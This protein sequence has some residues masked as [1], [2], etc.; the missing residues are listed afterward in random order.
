MKKITSLLSIILVLVVSM[1]CLFACTPEEPEPTP[2]PHEHAFVETDREDPTCFN[3]G[4]IK[5][6]CE[7][8][9]TKEDEIPALGHKFEPK[10][11]SVSRL[12]ECSNGTCKVLGLPPVSNTFQDEIKYVFTEADATRIDDIYESM[13]NTLDTVGAYDASKHAYAEGSELDTQNKAFEEVWDGYNAEL[14]FVVAQYQYAKIL[15]DMKVTNTQRADD[16]LYISNYYNEVIADYNKLLQL[17]YDSAFRDYF[18]YGM[19]QEEIDELLEDAAAYADPEYLALSN[20]NDEIEK[21]YRELSDSEI[22]T[23]DK[24]LELYAQVV[25]NNNKIAQIQG[26]SNY[27]EY[28]YA[29]IYDREYTPATSLAMYANIKKYISPELE[30]YYDRY[31]RYA[32]GLSKWSSKEYSDFTAMNSGSFFNDKLPNKVVNNFF[33]KVSLKYGDNDAITFYDI[34][35]DLI[36]EGH[37]FTG[38]YSGAYSWRLQLLDTPIV[39]F[40]YD[41]QSASTVVHE[42]GHHVNSIHNDDYVQSYDLSETHS[43]GLEVLFISYLA[44][45]LTEKVYNLYSTWSYVNNLYTICNAMAV[46]RFEQAVYTNTY[47]GKNASKIVVDGVIPK[48]NYDLLY[49]SIMEELGLTEV[50]SK[51]YWRYVTIESAGYYVS[52]SISMLGSIQLKANS[53]NFD[54]KVESYL[55]LITYTTENPDMNYAEVLRYAGL[56]SYDDENL[57][58]ALAE[59]L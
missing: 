42:F 19:T 5:S 6:E 49:T 16:Q 25:E 55:K 14:D 9:E 4:L 51:S 45:Q 15:S 3:K 56:Y 43:Q 8:G 20:A 10:N 57:F 54:E 28:A 18:Y 35:Q 1:T 2:P 38:D 36:S 40:G 24:V 53:S 13:V 47:T 34:L 50:G 31:V 11:G 44:D 58:K 21:Q 48:E 27:M 23:G 29:E 39:F 37:Y 52:Y 30:V 32:E 26:Y 59:I 12:V 17:V 46:D 7:C 41:Y 22:E 33:E